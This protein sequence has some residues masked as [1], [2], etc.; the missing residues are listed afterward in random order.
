[1]KTVSRLRHMKLHQRKTRQAKKSSVKMCS[2]VDKINSEFTV[3]R[4]MRATESGK[5]RTKHKMVEKEAWNLYTLS[6]PLDLFDQVHI[7][8]GPDLVSNPSLE[9]WTEF[10]LDCIYVQQS[11]SIFLVSTWT[12][13]TSVPRSMVATRTLPCR[14]VSSYESIPCA[15]SYPALQRNHSTSRLLGTASKL[16]QP[17]PLLS[18][19]HTFTGS[20]ECSNQLSFTTAQCDRR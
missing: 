2:C 4:V 16:Q 15:R 12:S 18:Q 9:R 11:A 20:R 5:E 17:V 10:G 13:L 7:C 19:A 6:P 8:S 1:M 3:E 14:Y